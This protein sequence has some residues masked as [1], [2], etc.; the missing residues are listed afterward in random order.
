LEL[1]GS[2][3]RSKEEKSW[4]FTTFEIR[5]YIQLSTPIAVSSRCSMIFGWTL[6]I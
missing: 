5:S 1:P 6:L 4:R 3:S 2:S